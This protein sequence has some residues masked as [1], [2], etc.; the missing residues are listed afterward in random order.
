MKKLLTRI[1]AFSAATL[2]ALGTSLVIF[3]NSASAIPWTPTATGLN[4]PGFNVFTGVPDV[5]NEADFVRGRVSGSSNDF[6]DPVNDAC[7]N[8][9]QYSVRVYVHNGANQTLNN[10]GTGPGVAHNTKVSVDVPGTTANPITGT[11]SASN[12]A[13]VTDNLTINCSGKTMNLSY[14]TGS[15]IEQRIDGTTSP[16]S[17][18]IVTPGGALIGSHDVNGDVWGC[19]EQRVL[20][21]LKV[22]VTNVPTPPQ[23]SFACTLSN[24]VVD[25]RTVKITIAPQVKNVTVIGYDV[26]WGDGSAHDTT[27]TSSHT[28]ANSAGNGPFTI[29]ARFEIKHANG[30]TE[31]VTSDDCSRSLSFSTTTPPQV[32][33]THLTNTGAGDMVG[34][35]TATSLVGAF[36][37]R[38]WTLGRSR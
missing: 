12:A 8:G 15:A 37:H 5:G 21:F 11:I 25:N 2:V 20:V 22:K 4:H 30:Q 19:F 13:T 17:D 34:I 6:T 10:N 26:N 27:A 7:A 33:A 1:A 38:K 18:S 32:K 31:F 29:T 35:F 14:V 23:E 24:F 3:G 9:T 28:Y 16:L 36:L